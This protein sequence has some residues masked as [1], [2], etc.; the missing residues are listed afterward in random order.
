MPPAQPFADPRDDRD[1]PFA[2]GITGAVAVP[3]Y[4]ESVVIPRFIA[5]A[6]SRGRQ[7]AERLVRMAGLPRVLSAPETVRTPSANTYRLWGTVVQHT[8]RT[9]AGLLAAAGYRLGTL[10]L[11]DYLLS[12]ASTV[13][14]G[15][16][17]L[18]ANVHLV[19]SNSLLTTQEEGDEITVTYGVRHGDDELRGVVAE[20]AMA[21]VTAQLRHT[22]GALFC[23]RRV[24]FAHRA[25][26][27]TAGYRDAFGSAEIAF[28]AG[29]DSLTLHRSDLER[30]L[31]TA[32]PALAAII[33]RTAG[34]LSAPCGDRPPAVPGLREVIATQLPDGRPSLAD[35]ARSLALSPRTLQRRLGE[36]GTTWRAELD[37]VRR[38]QAAGLTLSGR[39]SEARAARLGFAES[40]SLRRAMSRW[41]AATGE[42]DTGPDDAGRHG[43]ARHGDGR[44]AHERREETA[45]AS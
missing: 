26:T 42:T 28:D 30:P 1:N 22:T 45:E 33:R 29:R 11:F 14:E 3:V 32:D 43:D 7:E 31:A 6:S 41:D 23:P 34:A 15:L 44:R 2:T 18:S 24:L 27:R 21:V 19:S 37:A 20:F 35:A 10:D 40:R 39:G 25:P 13:G 17:Q 36:A 5:T 38:I 4:T 16:E 8:G 12:T 9:D